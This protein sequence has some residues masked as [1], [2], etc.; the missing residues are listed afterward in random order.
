MKLKTKLY[1][2]RNGNI[3]QVEKSTFF[4]DHFI[5]SSP[6]AAFIVVHTFRQAQVTAGNKYT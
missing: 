3:F 5:G 6:S 2:C 1:F 4:K